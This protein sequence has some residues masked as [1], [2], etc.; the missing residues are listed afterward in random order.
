MPARLTC[1]ERT[2]ASKSNL[3]FIKLQLVTYDFDF[4]TLL[5]KFLYPNKYFLPKRNI[6]LLFNM[7]LNESLVNILFN[8]AFMLVKLPPGLS[9]VFVIMFI[10]LRIEAVCNDMF[11]T[12]QQDD[13]TTGLADVNNTGTAQHRGGIFGVTGAENSFNSVQLE[14]GGDS[15]Q[16]I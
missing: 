16:T 5:R 4:L 11:D 13:R 3:Q 14:T 2:S 12:G 6:T 10:F 9:V 7:H 8:N 15:W 1:G